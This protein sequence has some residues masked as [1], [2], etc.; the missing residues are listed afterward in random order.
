MIAQGVP[1]ERIAEIRAPVG[2]DLGGRTPEE[3]AMSIMSE[4]LA[5][6]YGGGGSPM[7]TDRGMLEKAKQ[8]AAK[9]K[10]R[11]PVPAGL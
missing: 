2:L 1:V 6:R 11:Q 3:I 9:P 10:K 8:L 4:I 5:V 7:T